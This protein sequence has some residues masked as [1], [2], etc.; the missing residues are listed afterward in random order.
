MSGI[1]QFVISLAVFFLGLSSWAQAAELPLPDRPH[2]VVEGHGEVRQVP[3]IITLHM[4]VSATAKNFSAAKQQVDGNIARAIQA[5]KRFNVKAA[6]INASKIQAAP[7]YEW[8]NQQ[9]IYK[10]ER[11]TRQLEV[12]LTRPDDYNDLVEG[13]LDAGITRLQNIQLAF[14]N[15]DQLQEE[16]MKR[17]LRDAHRQAQIIA[18]ELHVKLGKIFQ[19]APQ[20]TAPIV[21]PMDM[22]AAQSK[23]ERAPLKLAGQTVEQTVRV[24]YLLPN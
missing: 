17:A 13:L 6:D 4:Q 9:R 20:A 22:V 16:A 12:R 15:R 7:Q 11:I 2:I 5:A 8:Q 23:S 19:V 3:D 21:R 1:K 18:S 24:V 14:S 10:G